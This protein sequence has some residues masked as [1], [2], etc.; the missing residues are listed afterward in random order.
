MLELRR[1]LII[2]EKREAIARSMV[3]LQQ[4]LIIINLKHKINAYFAATSTI[5][6]TVRNT[7]IKES[8]E[9]RSKFLLLRRNYVMVVINQFQCHTMQELAMTEEYARFV[10]RS[11]L[12]G[13]MVTL[14]SRKLEMIILVHQM[15]HKM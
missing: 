7:L 12:L 9:E 11:I 4:I 13:Y 6:T 3:H 1:N 8:I 14:Q 2:K 5:W 10:T 15:E